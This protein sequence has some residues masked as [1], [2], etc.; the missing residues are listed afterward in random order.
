MQ[1]M[2][3]NIDAVIIKAQMKHLKILE[4][5]DIGNLTDELM[6]ELAKS[7]GSKLEE[8]QFKGFTARDLTTIEAK[9]KDY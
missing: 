7:L 4:L 1:I 6:I 2:H 3:G 5:F 9:F 8:L